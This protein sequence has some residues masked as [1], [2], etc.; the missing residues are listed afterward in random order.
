MARIV[1]RSEFPIFLTIMWDFELSHFLNMI[2]SR[3]SS[4][5][6]HARNMWES[7]EELV[8]KRWTETQT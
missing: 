1:L 4:E 6:A 3:L 8:H 5:K 2:N 7:V